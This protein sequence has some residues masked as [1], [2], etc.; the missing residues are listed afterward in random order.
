M[1]IEVLC[2]KPGPKHRGSRWRVTW[3]TWAMACGLPPATSLH[4]DRITLHLLACLPRCDSWVS[5]TRDC[6]HRAH[7]GTRQTVLRC[8]LLPGFTA[9][10]Y[11]RDHPDW[12]R[13]NHCLQMKV[14]S[15]PLTYSSGSPKSGG[16]IFHFSRILRFSKSPLTK[17]LVH[18]PT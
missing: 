15:F 10:H 1:R 5:G 18:H 12:D 4:P 17:Y 16:I 11:P 8:Q 13:C 3:K 2:W 7:H 6:F 14:R 9:K